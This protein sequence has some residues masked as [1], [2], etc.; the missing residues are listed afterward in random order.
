MAGRDRQRRVGEGEGEERGPRGTDCCNVC[1]IK[2]VANYEI[3]AQLW[4][5]ERKSKR[6]ARKLAEKQG[7]S[8]G[9]LV[10]F[11]SA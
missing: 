4:R 8:S 6:R 3:F 5:S 7:K 2:Y 11:R 9:T 10:G 1:P